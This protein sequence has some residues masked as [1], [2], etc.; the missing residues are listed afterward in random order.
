LPGVIE[1]L[2][3]AAETLAITLF[4]KVQ[5]P[6]SSIGDGLTGFTNKMQDAF[7]NPAVS[8]AAGAIGAALSGI[9]AAFGR[10]LSAVGPALVGGLSNAVNLIVRFKDFLIPLVA[11]LVAYKTVMLAITVATKAWA[12]VQALL[13]I[14]LTANPIGL[15][16][17]AIA[18]L[19]AG[20]VVLY[21]R[22]E[23]FRKIVQTTWAAI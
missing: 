3:N 14:A 2:K 9:G 10:I 1:R 20:I 17:A 11:G 7:E 15:I 4:E 21:N 5:G 13:N 23:T 22:N 18:G 19:V 16:I 12:A 8:Q 6:L